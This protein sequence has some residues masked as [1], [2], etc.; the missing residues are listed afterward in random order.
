MRKVQ[1][2]EEKTHEHIGCHNLYEG[3]PDEEEV[4]AAMYHS[5]ET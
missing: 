4:M 2:R 3:G 1:H 5:G